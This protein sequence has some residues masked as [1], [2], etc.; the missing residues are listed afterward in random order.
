MSESPNQ[1]EQTN[2]GGYRPSRS[3]M[4]VAACR[5]LA[6]EL[7]ES[8]RLISDPFARHFVDERALEAA[9]ADHALQ[10]V[11]RLR[12][13]YID[14]CVRVMFA[15]NANTQVLLLGAGMDARPLRL[16]LDVPFFEVDLPD[17]LAYKQRVF[18]RLTD[19]PSCRRTTVGVDL[20]NAKLRPPLLSAGFDAQRP[21]LVIWEGVINYLDEAAATATLNELGAL[22]APDSLLVADYV[23][24][25]WYDEGFRKRTKSV[26]GVLERGG[27]RLRGGIEN[28]RGA[29]DQAGFD[30]IDDEAIELLP[31]RYGATEHPR[32]YPARILTARKR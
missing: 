31:S 26:A 7:P 23:E 21:T 25:S 17:T 1:A 18:D 13:R 32:H 28:M 12:T 16:D 6:D 14:E 15:S 4:L 24:M 11:I 19:R 5:A 8:E 27:E 3:A 20:G 2:E 29:L 22:L 10:R 9:R 30:V